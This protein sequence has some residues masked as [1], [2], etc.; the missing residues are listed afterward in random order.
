MTVRRKVSKIENEAGS[1]PIMFGVLFTKVIEQLVLLKFV[2][3]LKFLVASL[4]I[5]VTYIY[6]HEAKKKA[7][8]V[9]EEVTEE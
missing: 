9:K 4:L 1:L 6:R 8:E 5:A 2:V 7:E 3:A